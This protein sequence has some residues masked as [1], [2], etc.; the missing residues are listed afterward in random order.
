M[1]KV[2]VMWL[3]DEDPSQQV[4]EQYGH[5]FVKGEPTEVDE[6]D[7]RLGKFRSSV[8]FAIGKDAKPVESEHPEPVDPDAGSEIAAVRAELDGLHVKYDGRSG[9]DTLR[10]RLAAEKAKA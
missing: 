10:A 5:I 1:S 6:N 8:M 4:I 3:G 9:L 2:A 7:P